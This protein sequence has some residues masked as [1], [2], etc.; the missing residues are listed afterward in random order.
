VLQLAAIYLVPGV[1]GVVPLSLSDWRYV[2]ALFLAGFFLVEA[3]KWIDWGR[4]RKSR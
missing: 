2:V 3:V 4:T 1:F